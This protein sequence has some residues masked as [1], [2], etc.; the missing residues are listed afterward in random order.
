MRRWIV[1]AILLAAAAA[2]GAHAWHLVLGAEKDP[3]GHHVLLALYA[4][5]RTAI[6]FA[7][8]AC[9][10]GRVEPHSRARDPLAY[11]ACA[12]AMGAV[13]AAAGPGR[14][15]APAA[16]A[17]GDAVAVCGCLWL[18]ASVLALGR[19]FGVLPEARGLVRRGPYRFVRH[20][21]YLGE[22]T[23]VTGLAIAAPVP[24]NLGLLAAFV[25]AQT[26]RMHFEER[27]LMDAFT[28]Y[29]RYAE[30]TGRILPMIGRRRQVRVIPRAPAV[31]GAVIAARPIERR[32]ER[33]NSGICPLTSTPQASP[34]PDA[35]VAP[36]TGA[37]GSA[38]TPARVGPA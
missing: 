11:A 3:D 8:A 4:L 24:M 22:I 7:F 33:S 31:G 15:A 13:Y 17:V 20:P 23:A 2:V 6:A 34:G 29:A 27:A 9:T 28:D 1:P 38:S 21:V 14:G 5:L 18:L 30:R 12:V 25:A 16:L 37:F 36:A 26:V 10:V 19:C 35:P 32:E